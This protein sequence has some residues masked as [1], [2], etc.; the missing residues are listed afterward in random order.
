LERLNRNRIELFFSAL[1]VA[2]EFELWLAVHLPSA[3]DFSSI[4]PIKNGESP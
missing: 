2:F 1:I 3:H 4:L